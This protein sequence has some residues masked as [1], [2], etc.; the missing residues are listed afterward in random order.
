MATSFLT[1]LVEASYD[2]GLAETGLTGNLTVPIY[3]P[4]YSIYKGGF[5]PDPGM[6]GRAKVVTGHRA[7]GWILFHKPWEYLTKL[8]W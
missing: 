5:I 2:A 8:T 7:L 4:D 3:G 6:K 1:Q